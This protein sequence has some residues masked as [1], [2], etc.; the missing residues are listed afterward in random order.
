MRILAIIP[1]YFGPRDPDSRHDVLGSYLE[2]L[3][4]IAALN[5]AV[6]CL[7]RNFG[8]YRTR[9]F[10][11]AIIAEGAAPN[12]I[13]IVIVAMRERNLLADIGIAPELYAIEY[14]AGAPSR[15]PFHAQRLMKERA[16]RYDFYC[17]LEDDMA[18]HDPAFFAKLTW[19]QQQFGPTA[20]LAPTRVETGF[21]GT[22]GKVV[23]D[24]ELGED[25]FRPFRRA[26]QRSELQ[27]S[28]NGVPC[29]FELPSN[30]HAAAFFLTREQLDY[31]IAQ[32]SFDDGDDFWVGPLE[33][34]ATLSVGKVFDIYKATRPD[35]FFLEIHH[36][37]TVYA[38]R[39]P[40]AGRRYGEPPLLAIAQNAVRALAAGN[41]ADTFPGGV[42][43]MLAKMQAPGTMAEVLGQATG[44]AHEQ[45]SHAVRTVQE[46]QQRSRS[47]RWLLRTTL[48]EL[49][50]RIGSQDAR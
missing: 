26:G 42:A 22:P 8:P 31:W 37:G 17:Y 38:S 18:I 23:I 45:L 33:S 25:M 19:F 32:P 11:E 14:V 10:G 15:I 9:Y 12:V 2:P 27:A 30:P 6:V 44:A 28:W 36:Y 49:H 35:P 1:H 39:H 47:L 48:A 40:P 34:A 24:P 50:R 5:E 3:S 13:D 46:H 7:H 21:T 20:L 29:R 16:G 43:A 41:S 4:R